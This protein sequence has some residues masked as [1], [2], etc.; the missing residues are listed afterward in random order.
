[1]L[2]QV[3][4]LPDLSKLVIGAMCQRDVH[5]AYAGARLD[6][7]LLE[8]TDHPLSELGEPR[9]VDLEDQEGTRLGVDD[10]RGARTL[11]RLHVDLFHER[12]RAFTRVITR[13]KVNDG[14]VLIEVHALDLRERRSYRRELHDGVLECKLRLNRRWTI[15][16]YNLHS[17]YRP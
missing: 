16:C 13:V 1:M 9:I 2:V 8:R 12:S 5:I 11:T 17:Y 14:E 6:V 4:L 10:V 15:M 3:I 7:E